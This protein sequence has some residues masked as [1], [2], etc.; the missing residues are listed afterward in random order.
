M[1]TVVELLIIML[2]CDND[3]GSSDSRG[4]IMTHFLDTS[5]CTEWSITRSTGHSGF[6]V[7]GSPPNL[8]TASRI[9][10]KSTTAGTPLQNDKVK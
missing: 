6:I 8:L 7:A 3:H 5:T 4:N 1:M 10:A 9:A 2:V